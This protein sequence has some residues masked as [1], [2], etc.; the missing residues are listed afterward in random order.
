RAGTGAGDAR[1]RVPPG[2]A[3]AGADAGVVAPLLAARA[4]AAAD[5]LDGDQPGVPGGGAGWRPFRLLQPRLGRGGPRGV[6]T[7]S[8][9]STTT[10]GTWRPASCWCARRGACSRAWTARRTTRTAPRR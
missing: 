6:F 2:H 1:D 8:P 4:G 9:P 5:R 7:P 3:R 10:S